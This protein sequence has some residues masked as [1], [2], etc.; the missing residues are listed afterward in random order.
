M[1]KWSEAE[2]IRKEVE[3][4]REMS[5]RQPRY[6]EGLRRR[7]VAYL[8]RREGAGETAWT[9]SQE[10]GLPWQTLRRWQRA[11]DGQAEQSAAFR[12]VALARDERQV[13]PAAGLVVQGPQG[14]RVEGLTISAL[15]ELWRSLES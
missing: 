4:K 11:G 3:R 13:V 8:A 10:V 15:A 1:R 6:G 7:A 5:R 2:E 9:V 14:L 12:R